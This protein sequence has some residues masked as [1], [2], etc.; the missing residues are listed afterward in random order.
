[1]LRTTDSGKMESVF[2]MLLF[3]VF[4]ASVL[5]VLLSGGSIYQRTNDTIMEN[6][7]ERTSLS[8]IWSRVRNS[9]L[10]G[11]VFLRHYDAL[12]ITALV[13]QEEIGGAFYESLI[14]VHNGWLHELFADAEQEFFPDF[15]FPIMESQSLVFD[16]PGL[17]L[18][19]VMN[20]AGSLILSPRAG[21]I[22]R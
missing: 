20:S 17:G 6:Y 13:L 14:Y 3:A 11:R 2:V 22:S 19:K 7:D 8:F 9:D 10:A 12:D 4:A 15:G 18:I 1:M 16:D 5:I 21:V